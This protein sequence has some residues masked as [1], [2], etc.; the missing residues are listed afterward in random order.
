[1]IDGNAVTC[2]S[3]YCCSRDFFC[4]RKSDG[5]GHCDLGNCDARYSASPDCQTVAQC[6]PSFKGTVCSPGQCCDLT[7]TCSTASCTGSCDAAYSG[8]NAQ[9]TS[10]AKIRATCGPTATTT[11]TCA[12]G[13]C[14]SAETWTCGTKA[15]G[16][17]TNTCNSYYSASADCAG[18]PDT[19]VG[20]TL[21]SDACKT[22]LACTDACS[23]ADM[24]TCVA[25]FKTADQKNAQIRSPTPV[26]SANTA[27]ALFPSATQRTQ[28]TSA[29][30][31]EEDAADDITVTAPPVG[32]IAGV[33][34]GALVLLI[35]AWVLAICL[36]RKQREKTN[37]KSGML[38]SEGPRLRRNP[39]PSL[40]EDEYED[41]QLLNRSMPPRSDVR[42]EEEEEEEEEKEQ[43][44]SPE[45]N[46]HHH[47]H[48]HHHHRHHH[49]SSHD[50]D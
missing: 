9:C 4:G 43:E 42:L 10:P 47:H 1:M 30:T 50:E 35:A 24:A 14:C 22:L 33:I 16:F 37:T 15:D 11:T 45:S 25:T 38:S 27:T 26:T 3:G 32:A 21:Y 31:E 13:Q 7:G 28:P 8:P 17:C 2:A 18:Y 41:L 48:H 40:T 12:A 36:M 29:D 5:K 19:P 23:A 39:H 44:A 34:V 20:A 46:H 6:G 49:E